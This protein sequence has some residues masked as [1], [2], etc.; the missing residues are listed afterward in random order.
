MNRQRHF[1][2]LGTHAQNGGDPHP[3]YS[4]GAADGDS[5]SHAGDVARA[6]RCGQR[7]ANRLEGSQ[8][9]FSGFFLFEQ[10]TQ[11]VFHGVA[12]L[13]KGQE[14][15]ADRQIQANAKDADHGG[16]APDKVVQNLVDFRDDI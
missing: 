5:A 3:E 16:N 4:A 1:G 10:P 15:G 12:E 14:A 6:N 7:G 2:K 9:A 13:A 11:R 8:R